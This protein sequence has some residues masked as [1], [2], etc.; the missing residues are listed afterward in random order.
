[1]WLLLGPLALIAF[2]YAIMNR[3]EIPVMDSLPGNSEPE[4]SAE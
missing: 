4:P 2:L 3:P 1:M